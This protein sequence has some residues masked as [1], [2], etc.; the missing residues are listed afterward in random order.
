M[1][2][3][4]SGLP[5]GLGEEPAAALV[6]AVDSVAVAAA[7]AAGSPVAVPVEPREVEAAITARVEAGALPGLNSRFNGPAHCPSSRP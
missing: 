6:A 5:A 2:P 4:D 3:A 7:A 1:G